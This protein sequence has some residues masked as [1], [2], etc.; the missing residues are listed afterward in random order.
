MEARADVVQIWYPSQNHRPSHNHLIWASSPSN[1]S[2]ARTQTSRSFRAA[3]PS[4]T[5][6]FPSFRVATPRLRTIPSFRAASP[7]TRTSP[8]TRAA[9]LK[10]TFSHSRSAPERIFLGDIITSSL[11]SDLTHNARGVTSEKKPGKIWKTKNNSNNNNNNNNARRQR[12]MH[13]N[14]HLVSISRM[15]FFMT[16]HAESLSPPVTRGD[17]SWFHVQQRRSSAQALNYPGSE[18][19]LSFSPV[20][21]ALKSSTSGCPFELGPVGLAPTKIHMVVGAPRSYLLVW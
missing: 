10:E 18:G 6:S 8:I 21:P 4:R 15:A 3:S 2:R 14:L 13:S 1:P 11:D 16:S 7:R 12:N 9:S 20:P 17:S 5:R 19:A